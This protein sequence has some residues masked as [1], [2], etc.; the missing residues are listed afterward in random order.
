[1]ET[2]FLF[3]QLEKFLSKAWQMFQMK[4]GTDVLLFNYSWSIQM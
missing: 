1:M 3:V 4:V 2:D